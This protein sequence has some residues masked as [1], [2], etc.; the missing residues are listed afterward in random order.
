MLAL[1]RRVQGSS[2]I[3]SRRLSEVERREFVREVSEHPVV[4]DER[5]YSTGC[6]E[7]RSD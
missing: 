6:M 1:E 4:H 3:G 7:I 5:A 2:A